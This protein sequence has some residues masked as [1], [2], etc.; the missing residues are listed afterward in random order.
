MRQVIRQGLVG[1][2]VLL[3]L[4]A[5]FMW[6]DLKPAFSRSFLDHVAKNSPK[7]KGPCYVNAI[8]RHW[9]SQGSVAEAANQVRQSRGE[10]DVVNFAIR[11][12]RTECE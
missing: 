10:T 1:T 5:I 3:V 7:E 9:T 12:L 4:L 6:S 11:A 8:Q 2:F